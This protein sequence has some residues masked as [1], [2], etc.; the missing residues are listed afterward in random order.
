MGRPDHP[1]VFAAQ[2]YKVGF[3]RCVDV[4]LEF[5]RLFGKG[6]AKI[7]V[8]GSV[9]GLPLRTTLVPRGKGRHRLC[10]HSDIY[11]KLRIDA[12]AVVEVTLQLDEE[13]REPVLPPELAA[14]LAETP[15]A[16]AIFQGMTTSLRR[17]IVRYISSVKHASTLE[18]RSVKF[19]HNLLKRNATAGKS[20]KK[21]RRKK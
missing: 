3:I 9:E 15:R 1:R 18:R 8:H 6:T 20:H 16:M 12:G 14:A 10:I 21:A 11:R 2:I 7:L 4:P 19:V 17:Q 5:S 13:S